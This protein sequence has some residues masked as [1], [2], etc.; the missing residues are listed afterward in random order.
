[1]RKNNLFVDQLIKSDIFV[2]HNKT[3]ESFFIWNDSQIKYFFILIFDLNFSHTCYANIYWEYFV[4][5]TTHTI[6]QSLLK[7]E[8]I[9][10][11]RILSNERKIFWAVYQN[12]RSDRNQSLKAFSLFNDLSI[13]LILIPL[14]CF[15]CNQIMFIAI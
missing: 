15:V 7:Y 6:T 3:I 14:L 11:N 8:E 12:F 13:E 2:N 10:F 5:G 1:M 4:W 9:Y